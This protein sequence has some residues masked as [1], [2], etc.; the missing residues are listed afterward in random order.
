MAFWDINERRGPWSSEG[1]KPQ[2][3][4][5]PGQGS[6]SVWVGEQ[7]VGDGIGDFQRGKQER[8]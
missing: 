1:S 7:E 6:R 3:R 8:G 4:G 5:M 2:C